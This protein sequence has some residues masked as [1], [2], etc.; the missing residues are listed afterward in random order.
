MTVVCESKQ[1]TAHSSYFSD[2]PGTYHKQTHPRSRNMK[3]RR[4]FLFLLLGALW[5][6]AG[7][8]G[9]AQSAEVPGASLPDAAL[10]KSYADAAAWGN[11]ADPPQVHTHDGGAWRFWNVWEA[12]SGGTPPPPPVVVVTTPSAP[13]P[14]VPAQQSESGVGSGDPAEGWWNRG[15]ALAWPLVQIYQTVRYVIFLYPMERL[16]R[17]GPSLY[18]YG[19]WRGAPDDEICAWL[20]RVD[21]RFWQQNAQK[22]TQRIRS[23]I[24]AFVVLCE[25]ILYAMMCVHVARRFLSMVA[26]LRFT[27]RTRDG[28]KNNDRSSD[29]DVGRYTPSSGSGAGRRPGRC[30]TTPAIVQHTP[31]AAATRCARSRRPVSALPVPTPTSL[32]HVH[33]P[34]TPATP[35]TASG[36]SSH[37]LGLSSSDAT[38][39]PEFVQYGVEHSPAPKG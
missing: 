22:C 30:R 32:W 14:P 16:Y 18:G 35:P 23:E 15:A 19:F 17:H 11:V 6:E 5:W 34:T 20:T 39:S 38:P 36:G 29:D 2:P 21:T 12:W 10:S 28:V 9:V 31:P 1:I 4:L 37:G 8:W 27:K 13:I 24:E 7:R 3:H 33:A 25:S 26:N